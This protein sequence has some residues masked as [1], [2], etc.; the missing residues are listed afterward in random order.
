MMIIDTH[1]IYCRTQVKIADVFIGF[2][3]DTIAS[4]VYKVCADLSEEQV[5]S[6]DVCHYS[7][8]Y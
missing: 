7:Q 4:T 3:D 5:E 1:N 8:K 2:N 6:H